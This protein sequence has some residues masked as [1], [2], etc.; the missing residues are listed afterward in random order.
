M[1]C[2]SDSRAT[3]EEGMNGSWRVRGQLVDLVVDVRAGEARDEDPDSRSFLRTF[4]WEARQGR[5]VAEGTLVDVYKA[6]YGAM[7]L[8]WEFARHD[9]G[10]RAPVFDAI[11]RRLESAVRNGA[12]RFRD[13]RVREVA[14]PLEWMEEEVLGPEADPTSWIEIELLDDDGKPVPGEPYTIVTGNGRTRS[15]TLDARGR[16]RE[17]GIDPGECKVSFTRL[18]EW[19]AA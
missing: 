10:R 4:L 7:P 9:A 8:D 1:R 6:L 19:K 5:S 13:G 17:D 3:E 12:L 18:H 15:G 2:A 11:A 16:A 14:V